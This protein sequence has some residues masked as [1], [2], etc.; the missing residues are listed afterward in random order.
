MNQN[1][2]K[3]QGYTITRMSIETLQEL[4]DA[5]LATA[6]AFTRSLEGEQ[7]TA[8]QV[9]EF[10]NA[11]RNVTVAVVRRN[12]LPHAAPVIGGCVD[13][14]IHVT[15]SPGSVLANCLDR[16]PKVAFTA[17]DLVHTLIGAGTAE[18]LGRPSELAE[19]CQRLD[20]SSPFGKFAP[21]GWNGFIFRLRPNRLFAW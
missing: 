11:T 8:R 18:N 12:G 2:G 17:A 7:R 21:E 16:V 3:E 13:G 9:E 19:L 20:R 15:V 5:S 14:Q 4:L 10:I 1:A 6:S